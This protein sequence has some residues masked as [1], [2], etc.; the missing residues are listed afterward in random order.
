[1]RTA[2]D[3]I[4]GLTFT[5]FLAPLALGLAACSFQASMQ[6]GSKTPEEPPPAAP[7]TEPAPPAATE[8]EPEK[9]AKTSKITVKGNHLQVPGKLT[10]QPGTATFAADSGNEAVIAEIRTYLAESPRVT[11]LR[12]EGHTDNQAEEAP[13]LELS[14]QRA[15]MVKQWLVSAGV[16]QGRL[17]AVGF[18]QS[19]PIAN[20]ATEDGRAQNNRIEFRIAEVDGK[21]YLNPDPLAGGKEYP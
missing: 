8:P 15:S 2:T 10:F 14:G 19:K 11:R 9:P 18:G 21:P 12:I 1:V 5:A 20:N 16:N 4:K 6:A 3:W 17:I 13:S 7:A